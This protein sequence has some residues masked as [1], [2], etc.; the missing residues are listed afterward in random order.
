MCT[1]CTYNVEYDICHF[2]GCYEKVKETVED[3]SLICFIVF[4]IIF[5][6]EVNIIFVYIV[7]LSVIIFGAVGL[8]L[9]V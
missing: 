1:L 2:Q 3:Y 7:D 5:F 6:V 4:S 8:K 9:F